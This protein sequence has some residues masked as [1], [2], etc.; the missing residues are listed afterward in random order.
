MPFFWAEGDLYVK[1]SQNLAEVHNGLCQVEGFN[2]RL[3][4]Y[5]HFK[6]IIFQSQK[7][8]RGVQ[9]TVLDLS[10]ECSLPSLRP[11]SQYSSVIK[12]QINI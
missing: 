9:H 2:I 6:D 7:N 8:V 11:A 3:L 10:R 4:P 5:P 12:L 1:E